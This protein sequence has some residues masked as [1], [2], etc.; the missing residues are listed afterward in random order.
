MISRKLLDA[1]WAL[2]ARSLARSKRPIL[3][4]PWRSEVGFE[5]LY[6]IPFLAHFANTYGI[7]KNRLIAIGRGGSAAWYE[8]AGHADLFEFLP[9]EVVRSLSIQAAQQTGSVKQFDPEGWERHVCALAAKSLGIASYDVLSPTWMYRL[10]APF[11]DGHESLNWTDRYLLHRQRFPQPKLPIDLEKKLPESYIAMRWYSRPTWP[12]S[13]SNTLWTRKLV[14]AISQHTPVIL[15]NSGFQAD[16]HGDIN[17]GSIP[18]TIRLSELHPMQP[19]DNL[20]IQSG[21]IAR[22]QGYVGTYGGMAQGAMRWG[23]PTLALYQEFGQ[24]SP[25]HLHLTQSLSL[26]SGVPFVATYPQAIE[27]LL[28]LLQSRTVSNAV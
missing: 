13:E 12:M 23:V 1:R 10:L 27:R 7:D 18:N 2:K 26:K 21:V 6:W 19:I 4:G 3:A 15:I 22:A 25:M 11:W 17:L 9:P 20:T 28:P 16:D 24:T 8:A 5:L 14:E